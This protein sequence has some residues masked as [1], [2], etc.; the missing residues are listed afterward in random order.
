MSTN[1]KT[2]HCCLQSSLTIPSSELP[3]NVVYFFRHSKKVSDAIHARDDDFY[4]CEVCLKNTVKFIEEETFDETIKDSSKPRPTCI[5]CGKEAYY[6]GYD[7][8]SIIICDCAEETYMCRD[9]NFCAC[10]EC[11]DR[12]PMEGMDSNLCRQCYKIQNDGSDSES[13]CENGC[14]GP[15]EGLCE[16]DSFDEE[17]EDD[18]DDDDDDFEC[19]EESLSSDYKKR[20]RADDEINEE[21]PR[22]KLK[23]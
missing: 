1:D 4:L 10:D 13:E 20:K 6:C 8:C 12:H 3:E 17:E 5:D 22:K 14:I 15:C 21:H 16:E 9:C 23:V 18:D 11:D 2:C 19:E 7:W